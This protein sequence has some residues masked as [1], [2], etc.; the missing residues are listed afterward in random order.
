MAV[1]MKII[2]ILLIIVLYIYNTIIRLLTLKNLKIKNERTNLVYDEE[3][4]DNFLSYQK[5][6][7]NFEFW[8][9]SYN[10]ALVVIILA[11]NLPSILYNLIINNITNNIYL[12]NILLVIFF[13]V[14]QT[15]D[16]FFDYYEIFKIEDKYGFNKQTKKGFFI[17]Q[18]KSFIL[19]SILMSLLALILMKAF[20]NFKEYFIY[21]SLI[22]F[23]III[24]LIP[25]LYPLFNKLF[26]KFTLLEDGSL[27]D[28]I[29]TFLDKVKYPKSKIYIMDASKRTTKMNAYFMGYG[30]NKR[31]V[32]YDTL[33]DRMTED[34][35]VAVLAHEVGHGKHKDIIKRYP[36]SILNILIMLSLFYYM[37]VNSQFSL[38]FG[39]S[40]TNFVFIA[41]L[42]MNLFEIVGIFIGILSNY[43]SRKAEYNA[44]KFSSL[45]YQKE[46]MKTALIKLAKL[47]YSNLNPHP[48]VVFMN[49]SHPTILQRL[50]TIDNLDK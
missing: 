35:V 18:I 43:L 3:G 46:A 38:V 40:K 5:D 47:N 17:D 34:E 25:I 30:K 24:V 41:Y 36:L 50:D 42:F 7:I 27:K 2:L 6:V 13:I 20:Y 33:L 1:V 4:Y 9:S 19:L 14:V 49:Y 48:F 16:I 32:L 8:R 11:L 22:I 45:N 23:I 12:S 28:K 10:Y 37:L 21:I 31:I 26:N 39:F 15:L 29:Y 44:D